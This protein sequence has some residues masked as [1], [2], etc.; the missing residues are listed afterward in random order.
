MDSVQPYSNHAKAHL[1]P[2]PKLKLLDQCREVM[3]FKHL[4]YRTEDSYRQW[5]VRF[6]KFHK[7]GGVWR[8]PRDLPPEA[9]GEFLSDLATRLGVTASTQNQALNS[10]MFL[11]GDLNLKA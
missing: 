6:L 2:N 10:L 3:R 5:V 9:V 11:Y 4:S 8:N 7:R 1:L